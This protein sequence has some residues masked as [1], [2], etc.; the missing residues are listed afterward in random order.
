MGKYSPKMKIIMEKIKKEPGIHLIYSDFKTLSGIGIMSLVLEAH[1]FT[2]YEGK[3]KKLTTKSPRYCMYTGGT[4][5]EQ[6]KRM[7]QQ[8]NKS[9]NKHGDFVKVLMITKAGAEGLDL[10]N[11]R[12]VHIMEPYWYETRIQQVIGRAARYKSHQDLPPKDRYV[13][14]FRY[15]AVFTK[16][17]KKG[18]K[19]KLTTDQ[20]IRNIAMRKEKITSRVLEILKE[21]AF[22]CQLTKQITGIDCLKYP[23]PK[24]PKQLAYVPSIVQDLIISAQKTETKKV[25]RKLVLAGLDKDDNIIL[26]NPKTKR[27]YTVLNT[28]MLK[29]LKDKPKLVKK[30]YVE[31]E[32]Q[33]VFDYNSIRKKNPVEIGTVADDGK[34]Q[35]D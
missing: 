7:I 26:A 2:R 9:E 19:E 8:S 4:T 12:N 30:I 1:G 35:R 23:K 3:S 6:R 17:Q 34:L 28:N 29:P 21:A 20:Y 31:I 16:E 15:E 13:N 22:D 33:K 25:K 27:Y 24:N 14:V 32:T 11:I 18:L 5:M 10:K